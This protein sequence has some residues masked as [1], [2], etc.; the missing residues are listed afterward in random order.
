MGSKK[1]FYQIIIF[2]S[3][4]SIAILQPVKI[5]AKDSYYCS[6][7]KG[8]DNGDN[9]CTIVFDTPKED[10]FIELYLPQW[11][12][13]GE[14]ARYNELSFISFGF[15]EDNRQFDIY[16]RGYIEWDISDIWDYATI[17][18]VYLLYEGYEDSPSDSEIVSL[19]NLRP[20]NS[21]D[22]DL[23]KVMISSERFVS[24]WNPIVDPNQE[25]NLGTNAVINLKNNLSS[26]W[27]GIGFIGQE[28]NPFEYD[29]IYST[30]DEYASPAPTLK[31]IYEKCMLN[32][33][34]IEIFQSEDN[35]KEGQTVEFLYKIKN[36]G[37]TKLTKIRVLDSFF[38]KIYESN[39]EINPG[40][41]ITFSYKA[42][43]FSS[44]SHTAE[45]FAFDP[46]ENEVSNVSNSLSV[47]IIQYLAKSGSCI[48]KIIFVFISLI[49]LS[50]AYKRAK[51]LL[52]SKKLII[53]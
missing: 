3:I 9:T 37:S 43:I 23:F 7:G 4:A 44:F 12:E 32:S 48:Y 16:H 42:Q 5:K 47:N 29:A 14:Y 8:I 28:E 27:F 39:D 2:A 34:S 22:E 6:C 19:N 24:P 41:E 30:E 31:V 21:S 33:I 13:D 49:F 1:F 36:N 46:M 15:Y 20:Y 18:D 53:R 50:F 10:G 26:D 45:V 25:I 11:S 38:G 35:I 17:L 40:E 51:N 52:Q